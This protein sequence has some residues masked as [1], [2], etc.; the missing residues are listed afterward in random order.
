[1]SFAISR[2]E[3]RDSFHERRLWSGELFKIAIH[4]KVLIVEELLNDFKSGKKDHEDFWIKFKDRY[5][6]IRYFAVRDVN[7]KYAGTIE[8]TQDIG[9]IQAIQGEKRI[10]SVD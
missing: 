6:Y 3:K 8:F 9:P 4:Q 2:K 1:M 5:V 7:G 10:L